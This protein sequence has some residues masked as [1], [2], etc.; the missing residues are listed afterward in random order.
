MISA[1]SSAAVEKKPPRSG[2]AKRAIM[3]SASA[4]ACANQRSSKVAS[5]ERQQRLEQEG[6][7]LE[8]GVELRPAVAVGAKQPAIRVAQARSTNSAQ[9]RAASR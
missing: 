1:S 6:V 2:S 8:V 4:V 7:V 5:I 3:V 9:A